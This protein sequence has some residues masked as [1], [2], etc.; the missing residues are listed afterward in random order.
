MES[1]VVHGKTFIPYISAEE[2]QAKCFEI[3]IKINND[4]RDE[5][6]LF[7]AILN[8]SFLFAADLFRHIDLEAE[9]SF[10]KLV[11]YK[12]TTST[13][14]VVT[15]IGLDERVK[16]RH[17]IIIEDI[18]DTGRTLYQ[19]LPE[20]YNQNPKSLKIATLLTKPSA[21]LFDVHPDYLGFEIPDKFVLGYGLDFDGLG[22]NI[23]S[24]YQ[25]QE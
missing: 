3:A 7:I 12:G 5:K 2:I 22:R 11:S 18:L 25:L 20:L 19:F 1:I 23:P 14:N 8:G 16:D 13:G 4:Y 24:I 10:I 15:A 6:P 9:I 21:R 17:V